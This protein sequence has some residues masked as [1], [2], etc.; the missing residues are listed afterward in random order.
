M[1]EEIIIIR[2][3]DTVAA[4]CADFASGIPQAVGVSAGGAYPE[5]VHLEGVQV[6][7]GV[8]SIADAADD[9]GRVDIIGNAVGQVIAACSIAT[10]PVQGD[11]VCSNAVLVRMSA[12]AGALATA[13]MS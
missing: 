7:Q 5:I 12:I 1:P 3:I 9:G 6:L 10:S 11:E 8:A 2:C 4:Q 13:T